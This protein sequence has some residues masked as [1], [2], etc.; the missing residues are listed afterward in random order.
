M[1][2]AV[3]TEQRRPRSV[4]V[5]LA[6]C[7]INQ[8]AQTRCSGYPVKSQC[9]V[10]A[11]CRSNT[12][13][14]LW[15]WLSLL[16]LCPTCKMKWKNDSCH[17]RCLHTRVSVSRSRSTLVSSVATVSVGG[18]HLRVVLR[19]LRKFFSTCDSPSSGSTE[20][21]GT[22]GFRSLVST[23]TNLERGGDGGRR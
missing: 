9:K 18:G 17:N 8:I 12:G 1:G 7:A 15:R 11:L 20:P 13:I 14:Q 6:R 5:Q 4:L 23:T 21:V 22:P 16:G 10:P 3:E 19:I 2:T